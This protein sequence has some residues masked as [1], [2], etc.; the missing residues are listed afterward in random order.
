MPSI[1]A[2]SGARLQALHREALHAK[3]KNNTEIKGYHK[4]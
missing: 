2:L 4:K 1:N 3:E